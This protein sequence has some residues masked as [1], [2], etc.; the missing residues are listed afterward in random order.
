MATDAYLEQLIVQK[1]LKKS[2]LSI[3]DDISLMESNKMNKD[4]LVDHYM[5][6]RRTELKNDNFISLQ[7]RYN[8]LKKMYKNSFCKS[9]T[10]EVSATSSGQCPFCGS[11]VKHVT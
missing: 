7:E 4:D 3:M 11:P 5:R 1:N 8:K 9:C 10:V 6:H 2:S